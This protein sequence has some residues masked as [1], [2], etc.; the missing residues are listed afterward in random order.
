MTAILAKPDVT[1][2]VAALVC[3]RLWRHQQVI[4]LAARHSRARVIVH[5]RGQRDYLPNFLGFLSRG[6]IK[7]LRHFE[8]RPAD[9]WCEQGLESR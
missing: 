4:A 1:D 2:F 3:R 8:G 9:E 5:R 7:A 6:N